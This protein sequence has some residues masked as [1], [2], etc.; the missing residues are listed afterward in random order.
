[1]MPTKSWWFKSRRGEPA[2][3]TGR[4]SR[5]TGRHAVGDEYRHVDQ[6][7]KQ[8]FSHLQI[9]SEI[10]EFPPDI[11]FE[12]I[13]CDTLS[14]K[15]DPV[16]VETYLQKFGLDQVEHLDITH[17][18]SRCDVDV[19]RIK[20]CT[21]KISSRPA[22]I[23]ENM[24]I[25]VN[26]LDELQYIREDGCTYQVKL[27][28]T[29]KYSPIKFNIDPNI[30]LVHYGICGI[31]II[32]DIFPKLTK[33]ELL[34]R[35]KSK[36]M[37]KIYEIFISGMKYPNMKILILNGIT[38]FKQLEELLDQFPN[39]EILIAPE[40]EDPSPRVAE[41]LGRFKLKSARMI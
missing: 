24:T 18:S 21:C 1:M 7:Q 35:L 30:K 5:Q 11:V 12:H 8:H 23:Y 19:S 34:P 15:T 29:T 16:L 2:S 32:L 25:L 33:L 26:K 37:T 4:D 17:I 22:I 38:Y 3:H 27:G 36:H 40:L 39:L 20:S 10:A 31:S 14:L 6:I 28:T 13:T 9:Y 41:L